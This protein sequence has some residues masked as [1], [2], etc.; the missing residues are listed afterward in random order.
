L[1]EISVLCKPKMHQRHYRNPP[2]HIVRALLHLEDE[3]GLA[4][5]LKFKLRNGLQSLKI[6]NNRVDDISNVFTDTINS[7]VYSSIGF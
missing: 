6:G 4:S 2:L 1:G 5:H 3:A 7:T